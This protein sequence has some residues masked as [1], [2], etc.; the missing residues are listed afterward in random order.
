MINYFIYINKIFVLFIILFNTYPS[1]SEANNAKIILKIVKADS[2]FIKM[3][4]D[5]N[6]KNKRTTLGNPLGVVL[7]DSLGSLNPMHK[8]KEIISEPFQILGLDNKAIVKKKVTDIIK[9][10]NLKPEVLDR[11]PH[12]LSGGQRQRV[13]IARSLITN[14]II[15]ILDEPTSALDMNVLSII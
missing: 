10:V 14:Q 3:K 8:I 12:T 11:Y 6:Q 9:S 1:I 13:S 7:Q 5:I 4:S 2:G 15:L